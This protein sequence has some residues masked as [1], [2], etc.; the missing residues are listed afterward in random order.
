MKKSR[1]LLSMMLAFTMVFFTACDNKD[2]PDKDKSDRLATEQT[3]HENANKDLQN[4]NDGDLQGDGY[5]K[6][7]QN[8]VTLYIGFSDRDFVKIPVEMEKGVVCADNF[9]EA[10]VKALEKETG[11]NLELAKP[12][13]DIEGGKTIDFSENSGFVVGPPENQ[14][15][16]YLV[17]DN[18]SFAEMMLDS[19]QKTFDMNLTD[20]NPQR[21]LNIYFSVEDKPIQVDNLTIPKDKSWNEARALSFE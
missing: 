16:A 14:K 21:S 2:K 19:I 11:W 13:E 17:H 3:E 15:E 1:I 5:E 7:D 12:I 10:L 4:N 18:I 20:G 6:A 9:D 8:A